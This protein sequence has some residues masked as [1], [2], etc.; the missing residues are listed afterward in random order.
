MARIL[1]RF[2]DDPS[3]FCPDFSF[4]VVSVRWRSDVFSVVVVV[5][6]VVAVVAVVAVVVV[7]AAIRHICF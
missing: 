1:F 5:A 6:V 2:V 7:V 4:R 3:S